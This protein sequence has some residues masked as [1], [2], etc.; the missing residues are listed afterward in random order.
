MRG[1]TRRFRGLA[2][3]GLLAVAGIAGFE[4]VGSAANGAAHSSGTV[5]LRT[6]KLGKI[7]VNPRGLTLYLFMKDKSAHSSC[8]GQCATYWPPLVTKTKPTAG[9][10]IK[11]SLLSWTKRSDGTM[12]VTYNKHPLYLFVKD[13]AAGQVNGENFSAFGAKWYVVNAN[14]LKVLPGAHTGTT[15]TTTPTYTYTSTL[16]GY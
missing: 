1:Q 6:T 13:T 4:A 7:L 8:T 15:P 10:G 11:T 14:G 5:S 9:S 12:Q 16:P 2:V 3:I